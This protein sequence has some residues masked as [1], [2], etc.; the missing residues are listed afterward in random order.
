MAVVVSRMRRLSE[1]IDRGRFGAGTFSDGVIA[2]DR[3][4][5]TT[6]YGDGLRDRKSRVDGHDMPVD[7]DRV[8]GP[9]RCL[10]RREQTPRGAR[11]DRKTKEI[12]CLPCVVSRGL[13]VRV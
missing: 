7:E 12:S 11:P 8:G 4:E 3:R 10:R 6:G 2:A 13:G 5:P 1:K 9:R